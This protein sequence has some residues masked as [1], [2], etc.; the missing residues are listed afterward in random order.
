[1]SICP[2]KIDCTLYSPNLH[3]IGIVN[4]LKNHLLFSGPCQLPRA[5][6]RNNWILHNGVVSN[7]LK[8]PTFSKYWIYREDMRKK[9]T[10]QILDPSADTA[11]HSHDIIT[12]LNVISIWQL[13]CITYLFVIN[14]LGDNKCIFPWYV[15]IE[16]PTL[17]LVCLAQ[18]LRD[19]G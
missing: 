7:W 2:P 10:Q 8:R 1:M 4:R 17:R 18:I 13:N 14:L 19:D 5:S 16:D 12:V 11:K 9:T 6:V 3:L 15:L